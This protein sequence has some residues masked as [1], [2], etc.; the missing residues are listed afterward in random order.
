M[1]NGFEPL[2]YRQLV[3]DNSMLGESAKA[4][5]PKVQQWFISTKSEGDEADKEVRT[6]GSC[7]RVNCT[8]N[9]T[10]RCREGILGSRAEVVLLYAALR[11]AFGAMVVVIL[12]MTTVNTVVLG[13]IVGTMVAPLKVVVFVVETTVV[14]I[15]VTILLARV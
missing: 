14:V 13:T 5:E 4:V 2:G 9:C 6:K 12:P 15:A 1:A 8:V 11:D 10:V 3:T 7:S